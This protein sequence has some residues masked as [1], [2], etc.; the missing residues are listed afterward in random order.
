ML[1]VGRE[2]ELQN[3]VNRDL[4]ADVR[5]IWRLLRDWQQEDVSLFVCCLSIIRAP[6][7]VSNLTLAID[8]S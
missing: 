8:A 1:Q 6:K 7:C 2:H 5:E 3:V 4:G